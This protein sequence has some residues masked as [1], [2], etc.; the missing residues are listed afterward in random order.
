MKLVIYSIGI[1][2]IASLTWGCS[3]ERDE[4]SFPPM[5]YDEQ[6]YLKE[7]SAADDLI[8]LNVTRSNYAVALKKSAAVT[9]A[10]Q[11]KWDLLAARV[12]A[13]GRKIGRLCDE[14]EL[15]EFDLE[16]IGLDRYR[17][18]FLFRVIE[19]FTVKCGI[20]IGGRLPD[21]ELLPEPD[22]DKG[23]MKWHFKPLPPT[24]FWQPSEYLVVSR[25]ITAPG[26]PLELQMTLS[27]SEGSHGETVS[28]GVM[29]QIDELE[30][31]REEIIA[32]E[33]PF[34]LWDWLQY[35]HARSGPLGEM[36]REQYRKVT[37]SL[38]PKGIV[39][40]G[41]EYY[42]ARVL[43]I[44]PFRCRL[45]ILFRTTG[46]IDRDYRIPIYGLVSPED[47]KYLSE[48]RRT[49]GKNEEK[50]SLKIFPRTSSWKEG[51]FDVITIDLDVAPISYEL[52]AFLY[53]L[54]A[55]KAG[56]RFD[57]GRLK[58]SE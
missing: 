17:L 33:D 1:I 16:S 21:P 12:D 10:L 53:D 25:D 56:P 13:E 46:P 35:C 50:W 45:Q 48:P 32:E 22:R 54:V 51:V 29:G 11:E 57:L 24:K 34:Q 49:A 19:Q 38:S 36:V 42:K 18:Y 31:S 23:Y 41:I 37:G 44:S 26:L 20:T 39:Q 52:F 47:R 9:T 2:A 14:A 58:A 3:P 43:R 4:Y 55:K 30:I 40:D 5:I 15:I 28:L 6:A 8:T 7:I 27:S